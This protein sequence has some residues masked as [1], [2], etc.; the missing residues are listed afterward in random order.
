MVITR[1]L[2]LQQP[3][4]TFLSNYKSGL[5][6]ITAELPYPLL[7]LFLK[8]SDFFNILVLN[9]LPVE[10]S[11]QILTSKA[12]QMGSEHFKIFGLDIVIPF[13]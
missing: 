8:F 3:R 2:L 7:S 12:V 5:V 1:E 10:Y 9:F 6:L 11:F 4:Y 13:A